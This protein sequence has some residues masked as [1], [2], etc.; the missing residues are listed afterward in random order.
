MTLA[1]ACALQPGLIAHERD[2]GAERRR[3][4]A[5]AGWAMHFTPVAVPE[6]PD[7]LLL[8]VRGSL[9]L[10]GGAEALC[11]EIRHGLH[12]RGHTGCLALT[13]TP[14]G[15][16]LLAR[17]ALGDPILDTAERLRAALRALPLAAAPL[18]DPLLRRLRQ[19]GIRSLGPLL[20]LPRSGLARR[21]GP[22]LTDWLARLLGEHPEVLTPWQPPER[23]HRALDLPHEATA[24]EPLLHAIR[25]LLDHLAR[26]LQRRNAVV[27]RL[28]LTL[29]HRSRPATRVALATRRP[30]ADMDRLT[31]LLR[32]RLGRLPL[33]GP[34]TA[35]HLA[36]DTPRP[37]TPR[38]LAL[39][40]ES[41]TAEPSWQDI[42]EEIEARLGPDAIHTPT[43]PADPR[44]EPAHT[45]CT[46][47]LPQAHRPLWLL[48][49][50][51]PL[52]ARPHACGDRLMLEHGPERIEAGWWDGNDMRRDYHIARDPR[53]LS[54]WA[55]RDRRDSRWHLHGFSAVLPPPHRHTENLADRTARSLRQTALQ[56]SG[57]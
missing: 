5:L 41:N 42:L 9:S 35:L 57:T 48:P 22:E 54:I 12:D 51:Q 36:T 3:L 2:P 33:P 26:W 43:L 50:P 32:I 55:F 17:A 49:Q 31:A 19:T 30:T 40:P 56:S 23:Y 38:N 20:R 21:F 52:P 8:E 16:R 29:H 24:I 44:P 11:R 45:P 46:P 6:P 34:V 1:T 15:S 53:G 47:F 4:E 28:M 39:F 25:T 18:P 13:P 37:I 10:F 14:E 7:L 27:S